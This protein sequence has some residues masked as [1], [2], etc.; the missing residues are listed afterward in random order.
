ME[1][2]YCAVRTEFLYNTDT[3]PLYKLNILFWDPSIELAS[4]QHSGA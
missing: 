4:C 1:S 2:V 3:F